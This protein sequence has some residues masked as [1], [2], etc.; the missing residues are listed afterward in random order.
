MG[1]GIEASLKSE[2]TSIG[3]DRGDIGERSSCL[4]SRR[5]D[6]KMAPQTQSRQDPRTRYRLP[7]L[8]S[9][10]AQQLYKISHDAMHNQHDAR[11]VMGCKYD[12]RMQ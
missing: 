7:A 10:R 6:G 5:W 12:V 3:K 11:H 2:T 9:T 8:P 1:I 4:V